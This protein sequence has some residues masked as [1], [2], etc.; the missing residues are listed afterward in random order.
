MRLM[1]ESDNT[2]STGVPCITDVS[3]GCNSGGSGMRGGTVAAVVI[4]VLLLLVATLTAVVLVGFL[5]RHRRRLKSKHCQATP[6]L[7][8]G[9]CKNVC[10]FIR[11]HFLWS[12][13]RDHACVMIS[14]LQ[15]SH[16]KQVEHGTL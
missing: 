3:D 16:R 11:T 7:S 13:H 15:L 4:A 10:L 12:P 14:L 6:V 9:M 1:S 2:G 8:D 5:L